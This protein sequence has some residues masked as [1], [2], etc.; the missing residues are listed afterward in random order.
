MKKIIL[1]SKSPYRK[2]LLNRLGI[3]FD[4]INSD[5]DENFLKGQIS[6]PEILTQKL[7]L[8]KAKSVQSKLADSKDVLVIGSDQVCCIDERILGKPGCIEAAQTQLEA[9]QG[10]SHHLMTSYVMLLNDQIICRTNKTTL[11]AKKLTIKQIKNYL[12]TDNPIDCAGSYKL[13]LNGISLFE[14]VETEDHTAIIG[15][16][17]LQLSRDLTDLGLVIPPEN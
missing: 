10:R 11:F 13:E 17:L 4:T 8:G 3:Q 12:S 15:L 2:A 5:F 16:P 14:K 6:D 9:L 1:A 7:A